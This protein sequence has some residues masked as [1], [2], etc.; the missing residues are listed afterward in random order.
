LDRNFFASAIFGWS[1]IFFPVTLFIL[2][3]KWRYPETTKILIKL[4]E[5][6]DKE[7]EKANQE[8][9]LF[10][11]GI[12]Y[13]LNKDKEG[14]KA[15]IDGLTPSEEAVFEKKM[16]EIKTFMQESEKKFGAASND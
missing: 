9:E 15:F 16:Q 3:Q 10:L 11:Q 2:F 13:V 14:F 12:E 1:V 7:M 5:D 8:L 4:D 6:F